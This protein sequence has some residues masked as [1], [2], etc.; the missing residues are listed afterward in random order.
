MWSR[1]NA[2]SVIRSKVAFGSYSRTRFKPRFP[3]D[4]LHVEAG[5]GEHHRPHLSSSRF[6]GSIHLAVRHDETGNDSLN[7]SFT[8]SSISRFR[9]VSASRRRFSSLSSDIFFELSM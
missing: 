4:H 2:V 9:I 8:Q 1:K 3:R 5:A 7:R 6:R